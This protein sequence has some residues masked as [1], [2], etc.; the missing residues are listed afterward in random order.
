MLFQNLI[1]LRRGI[2][3]PLHRKHQLDLVVA[4]MFGPVQV[5]NIFRP[6]TLVGGK[7][8]V[9]IP[10]RRPNPTLPAEVEQRLR[11]GLKAG[12]HNG[13]QFISRHR[14]T[15]YRVRASAAISPSICLASLKFAWKY[16]RM[17]SSTS[18]R[19]GLRRE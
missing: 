14:F 16:R 11:I 18:T 3:W 2:G 15:P 4:E 7:I 17:M 6:V 12:G 19:T 13:D 1:H 5:E 9:G 10:R 8:D